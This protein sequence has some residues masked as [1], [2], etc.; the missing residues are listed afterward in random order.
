MALTKA[1]KQKIIADLKDKIAKQKAM[2]LIGI[3]GLKVKDISDLRKKLKTEEGNLKVVKKTLIEKAFKENNLEF[4]KNK[5]KEE[6]ALVLGFKDEILPAKTVYQFGLA[7]EKLKILGGFLEGKFKEA[8][9]IIALAQLPTKEGLLAKLVG[10]IASPI[11]GLINVLQGN[12]KGLI[13][14]LARAKT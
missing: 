11:S 7:N 9:E 4:D 8:E 1:Q 14:V 13:T 6:I 3:T 5:Y 10:S 2:V 12:I